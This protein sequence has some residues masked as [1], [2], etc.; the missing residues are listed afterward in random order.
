MQKKVSSSAP[1]S[2]QSI[3]SSSSILTNK[4]NEQTNHIS[5]TSSFS[6]L[7]DH[8]L[9][10]NMNTSFSVPVTNSGSLSSNKTKNNSNNDD[11]RSITSETNSLNQ[12]NRNYNEVI[13]GN[14][15]V[16]VVDI[17]KQKI[18]EKVVTL[19][20]TL[21]KRNEKIDFLQDHVN[22]LTLDLQR[23]TRWVSK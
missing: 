7:N 14:D 23:K 6:S 10:E 13:C 11:T 17:D 5:R 18:I 22:Q 3:P 1:Q 2:A 8:M 9:N 4:S 20:K 15:D 19:Q 21:A 12:M 16:Y